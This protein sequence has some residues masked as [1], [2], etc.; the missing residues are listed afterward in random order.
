MKARIV[1]GTLLIICVLLLSCKDTSSPFHKT[2]GDVVRAF[3]SAANAGR[4]SDAKELFSEDG[5]KLLDSDLVQLAGGIKGICDKGTK[6]GTIVKVDIVKEEIR[7]EGA[8]V[9]AAILFK[10]GSKNSDDYSL[11]ME[12]GSWK[13]TGG[14]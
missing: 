5:R 3:Y 14:D 10:D 12:K 4:Y 8:H 7:G 6:N 1:G 13:L 11:I 9:S 2:P